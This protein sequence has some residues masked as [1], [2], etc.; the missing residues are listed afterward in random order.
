MVKASQKCPECNI[1]II[2]VR[3]PFS[4]SFYG[5]MTEKF[6]LCFNAIP[7]KNS[8][9][10]IRI[11]CLKNFTETENISIMVERKNTYISAGQVSHLK[12]PI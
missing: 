1:P 6:L 12:A 2:I 4:S 11:G 8:D 7:L 9:L 5:F 3:L 10:E